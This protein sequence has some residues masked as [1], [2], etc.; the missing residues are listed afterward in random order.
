MEIVGTIQGHDVIYVP[1]KDTIFCKNT[2]VKYDVMNRIINSGLDRESVP[3]KNLVIH[4]DNGTIHLGCL[5][6]TIE[7]CLEIR[8]NIKRFKK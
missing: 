2:A 3:E 5:T 4:K 7:N 6:T 1:E 8:R